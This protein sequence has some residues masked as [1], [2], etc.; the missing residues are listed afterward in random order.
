MPNVFNMTF[1]FFE[2]MLSIWLN[3]I[4]C[5]IH[6]A[7]PF[8]PTC[9]FLL[10]KKFI[11]LNQKVRLRLYI[12]GSN[13]NLLFLGLYFSR[14]GHIFPL[15][16]D[17]SSSRD[18]RLGKNLCYNF[19]AENHIK[20]NLVY[21]PIIFCILLWQLIN[22]LFKIILNVIIWQFKLLN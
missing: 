7:C 19:V 21:W 15:S 11:S 22:T 5:F 14:S 4:N 1:L 12:E 17:L 9:A 13:I 10:N 20:N 3:F 16:C 18:I 2:T 8:V 6:D